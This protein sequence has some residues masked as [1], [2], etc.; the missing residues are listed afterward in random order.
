MLSQ[1]AVNFV[2]Q[3]LIQPGSG[4][5]FSSPKC[6]S[7]AQLAMASGT[8]SI[9]H[10]NTAF[11]GAESTR[12]RTSRRNATKCWCR[13]GK[14]DCNQS[15]A[16]NIPASRGVPT[17]SRNGMVFKDVKIDRNLITN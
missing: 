5:Q 9:S 3:S 16:R 7:C 13:N 14:R 6:Q 4:I 2:G 1:L 15:S 17:E 10:L 8:G 11:D 12:F